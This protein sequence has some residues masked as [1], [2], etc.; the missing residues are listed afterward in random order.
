MTKDIHLLFCSIL[1][2]FAV[3][4]RKYFSF[5]ETRQLILAYQ[6]SP[7]DWN[8][9]LAEFKTN[10]LL[11]PDDIQDFYKAASIADQTKRIRDKMS[12]LRKNYSKLSPR[13]K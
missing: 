6:K 3:S 12:N 5:E 13:I 8:K 7:S 4:V 9:I 2:K 11:L 1:F 10:L